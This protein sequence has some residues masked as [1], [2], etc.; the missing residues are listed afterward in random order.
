MRQ[1]STGRAPAPA[2]GHRAADPPAYP[3]RRRCRRCR[4]RRQGHDA[5]GRQ[6]R[7]CAGHWRGAGPGGQGAGRALPQVRP[8]AVEAPLSAARGAKCGCRH[9]R[10]CASSPRAGPAA[11]SPGSAPCPCPTHPVPPAT[12]G[13]RRYA[14]LVDDGT[15]K[16]LNMEV[17]RAGAEGGGCRLAAQAVSAA[18]RRAWRARAV[19]H[20]WLLFLLAAVRAE[21]APSMIVWYTSAGSP[22]PSLAPRRRV[23][24]SPSAVPT[25]SWLRWTEPERQ[26]RPAAEAEPSLSWARARCRDSWAA[27]LRPPLCLAYLF[28]PVLSAANAR[29]ACC[30]WLEGQPAH[31]STDSHFRY[32][33]LVRRPCPIRPHDAPHCTHPASLWHLFWPPRRRL[34]WRLSWHLTTR[35]I[36][37]TRGGCRA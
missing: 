11:C 13:A 26:S 9:G 17:R 4:C 7:V 24:P 18:W 6:R 3:S 10:R 23:A 5:G 15:V 30:F 35:V 32:P 21:P 20:D 37:L 1:R 14:M 2:T 22:T 19:S 33:S 29:F 8:P 36:A 16:K 12:L 28:V 31:I 25:T 34:H 27:C